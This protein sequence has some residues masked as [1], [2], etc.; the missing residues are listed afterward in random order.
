MTIGSLLDASE[1]EKEKAVIV[2]EIRSVDDSPEE[3][4][5]DR[6]LR[7][8][9]G[10]HPLSRKITGEVEEVQGISRDDLLRF[11]R[12]RLVPANTIIAVA[13]NFDVDEVRALAQAVY[14]ADAPGQEPPPRVPPCGAAR[15]PLSPTVSTR[16]RSTQGPATPWTTRYPTTIPPLYSAP[17][18]VSR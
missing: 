17:P 2:N 8:M 6:Y 3:K 1:M 14:P 4:G 9:W 18:S 7:E 16:C 13:G 12:E 11:S 5:H 10:E 15:S